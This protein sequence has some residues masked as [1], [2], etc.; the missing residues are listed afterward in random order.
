GYWQIQSIADGYTETK[1]ASVVSGA[2]NPTVNI[3]LVTNSSYTVKEPKQQSMIPSQGGVFDDSQGDTGVKLTIPQNFNSDTGQGK[4][5]V[6]ETNA[7]STDS[8][9][10][11]GGLAKEISI[12]DS[13]NT[14]LKGSANADAAAGSG[15]TIALE[16]SY[17]ESN[18][19]AAGCTE[20][21]ISL[22]Y[23][24]ES[25]NQWVAVD[26]V[27]DQTNNV[28]RAN[29][30]HFSLYAPLLPSGGNPP[31]TPGTPSGAVSGTSIIVSWTTSTDD[32]SVAGY[33]VYRSTAVDG[34]FSNVSGDSWTTGSFVSS[35]LVGTS[36]ANGTCSWT[37]SSIPTNT[38]YYYKVAA[39]DNV[40]S[41]STTSASSSGTKFEGII[42]GG[43]VIIGGGGGTSQT[44]DLPVATVS[45][46]T[47]VTTT[48]TINTS[49]SSVQATTTTATPTTAPSTSSGQAKPISQMTIPE[50]QAEIVRITALINQLIASIGTAGNSGIQPPGLFVSGITK[51]LKYGMSDDQIRTLQT[52]LASD[53]SVYPEGKITGYFGPLTKA[54]VIKFQEKYKSEILTP[55]GL[56]N[57]TGLVGASTRAKLNSLFGQ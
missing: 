50:L 5:T 45:T 56:S 20:D 27:V 36:C 14:A 51:V 10:P 23:W 29:T 42:G 3:T 41:N 13:N 47:T 40:G 49:T 52:W 12:Y 37:N 53:I 21:Q 33:E 15:N 46:T 18:I 26:A 48:T 32:V 24:N 34:T 57:G 19:T 7:P 22:G 30:S 39:F 4:V 35:V 9:S 11:V 31:S 6:R 8:R 44:A 54:A 16:I 17:L 28:I 55:L 38:T 2:S 43:A 25:S 1:Y